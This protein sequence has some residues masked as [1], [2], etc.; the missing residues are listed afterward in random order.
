MLASRIDR[1]RDIYL[2]GGSLAAAGLPCQVIWFHTHAATARV[3]QFGPNAQV[4][5]PIRLIGLCQSWIEV[6]VIEW[7]GEDE[8]KSRIRTRPHLAL[9]L[10]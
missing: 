6:E 10:L 7:L 1:Q 9:A 2:E 8:E 5:K 3:G 4:S